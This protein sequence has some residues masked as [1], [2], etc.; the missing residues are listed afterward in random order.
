LSSC[1]VRDQHC[2]NAA[3]SMSLDDGR[4]QKTRRTHE[5]GTQS[6]NDA[7]RRPKVGC[8]R[9][10]PR[11]RIR[12]WCRSKTDSATTERSPPCRASRMMMTMACRKRVKRSR[13]LRFVSDSRSFRIQ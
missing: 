3:E 2:E 5:Q 9:F 13:M 8:A 12:T 10:R 6:R 4:T 11:F 7:I 1:T